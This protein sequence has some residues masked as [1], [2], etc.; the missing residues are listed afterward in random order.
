[1]A[2]S[3]LRGCL[4][5]ELNWRWACQQTPSDDNAVIHETALSDQLH[6][7]EAG[8]RFI[9]E[10]GTHWLV[11]AVTHSDELEGFYIVRLAFG[12]TE[13]CDHGVWAFG[14]GEYE[15][16]HR[17]RRLVSTEEVRRPSFR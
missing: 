3:V 4:P 13:K 5:R 6:T 7:P 11:E 2:F 14:R 15:A 9:D 1:M 17:E 12:M 10:Q 8:Q 16:L